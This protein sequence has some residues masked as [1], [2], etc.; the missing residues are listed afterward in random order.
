MTR[1]GG[2]RQS[3][4]DRRA[5][6]HSTETI[7][8]GDM[9]IAAKQKRM[10]SATAGASGGARRSAWTAAPGQNSNNVHQERR[11]DLSQDYNQ[12]VQRLMA[13]QKHGRY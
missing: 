9:L 2:N 11:T 6:D 1:Y 8:Q 4:A 7:S 13:S 12:Y 5:T 10:M 3:F